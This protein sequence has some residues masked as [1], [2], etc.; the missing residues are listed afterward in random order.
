MSNENQENRGK[1]D[2]NTDQELHKTVNNVADT[3]MDSVKAGN[4]TFSESNYVEE[5][6]TR[7][8]LRNDYYDNMIKEEQERNR[9]LAEEERRNTK[10]IDNVSDKIANRM[11]EIKVEN[12]RRRAEEEARRLEYEKQ[13]QAAQDE[14]KRREAENNARRTSEGNDGRTKNSRNTTDDNARK[15]SE[16]NERRKQEELQKNDLLEREKKER[17]IKEEREKRNIV[18]ETNK[19]RATKQTSNTTNNKL[20]NMA[21]NLGDLAKNTAMGTTTDISSGKIP[22]NEVAISENSGVFD[23]VATPNNNGGNNGSKKVVNGSNE[24]E[25]NK[26]LNT[27]RRKINED[28]DYKKMLQ[29]M[30]KIVE[31]ATKDLKNTDV[32]QTY[33]KAQRKI[34]AVTSSIAYL[35][36]NSAARSA[37]N[38]LNRTNGTGLT[39]ALEQLG[40]KSKFEQR[41]TVVTNDEILGRQESITSVFQ[42]GVNGKNIGKLSKEFDLAATA[43]S[44]ER[45]FNGKKP[46]KMSVGEIKRILRR[47][48]GE[49]SDLDRALFDE[50][51]KFKNYQKYSGLVSKFNAMRITCTAIISPFFKDTDEAMVLSEVNNMANMVFKTVKMFK[52]GQTGVVK[53]TAAYVSKKLAKTTEPIRNVAAGA[54]NSIKKIDKNITNKF[55]NT[56]PMKKIS[57]SKFGRTYSKIN[58]SKFSQHPIK[59]LRNFKSKWDNRLTLKTHFKMRINGAL[60]KTKVGRFL[61]NSNSFIN[62]YNPM[63]LVAKFFDFFQQIKMALIKGVLMFIG[64]LMCIVIIL[65]ITSTLLDSNGYLNDFSDYV[66]GN[67]A[68]FFGDITGNFKINEDHT[69]VEDEFG[70][71][72][73]QSD[74][75][76]MLVNFEDEYIRELKNVGKDNKPTGDNGYRDTY[77]QKFNETF[78]DN[79]YIK[80]VDQSG[81]IIPYETNIKDILSLASTQMQQDRMKNIVVYNLYCS[82][83]WHWSHMYNIKSNASVTKAFDTYDKKTGKYKFDYS[84][85]KYKYDE[86][87]ETGDQIVYCDKKTRMTMQDTLDLLKGGAAKG[88]VLATC[89]QNAYHCSVVEDL[90][91]HKI[92]YLKGDGELVCWEY[93]ID[94]DTIN[95]PDWISTAWYIEKGT[96][97]IGPL[98]YNTNTQWAA[99]DGGFKSGNV[100]CTISGT[101]HIEEYDRNN[102]KSINEKY[103]HVTGRIFFDTV[104]TVKETVS[105]KVKDPET[106]EETTVAEIVERKIKNRTTYMYDYD[107]EDQELVLNNNIVLRPAECKIKRK[108]DTSLCQG[109]CGGHPYLELTGRIINIDKEKLALEKKCEDEGNNSSFEQYLDE[110]TIYAAVM[111]QKYSKQGLEGEKLDK[112]VEDEVLT[113][114]PYDLIDLD[115]KKHIISLINVSLDIYTNYYSVM[116]KQ[117]KYG[118]DIH[119]TYNTNKDL[120]KDLIKKK[121]GKKKLEDVN[122]KGLI[123]YESEIKERLM[124]LNAFHT[125]DFVDSVIKEIKKDPDLLDKIQD[126][127][128]SDLPNKN[129]KFKNKSEKN[130]LSLF[131]EEDKDFILID[132]CDTNQLQ[133][134]TSHLNDFYDIFFDEDTKKIKINTDTMDLTFLYINYDELKDKFA[135]EGKGFISQFIK[136][137]KEGIDN[138]SNNKYIDFDYI[139]LL[140]TGYKVN[141]NNPD[142]LAEMTSE[143]CL[144]RIFK[145]KY[146]NIINSNEIKASHESDKTKRKKNIQ[147]IKGEKIDIS[148]IDGLY[149]YKKNDTSDEE[150]FS[151]GEWSV[152]DEVW[153]CHF[154]NQDWKEEYKLEIEKKYTDGIKNLISAGTIGTEEMSENGYRLAGF[155]NDLQAQVVVEYCEKVYNSKAE[156]SMDRRYE[157]P[158]FYDCSSLAYLAWSAAGVDMVYPKTSGTIPTAALEASWLNNKKLLVATNTLK[159]VDL[160]PGDLI[161]YSTK[162]NRRYKNITH[163]AIYVGGGYRIHAQSTKTGIVKDNKYDNGAVVAYA[164]PSLL[165]SNVPNKIPGCKSDKKTYMAYTKVT[166]KDSDQY[167]LLNSKQAKTHVSYGIRMIGDRYCV[168]VGTGYLTGVKKYI[169]TKIDVEL[170]NGKVLKCIV[171]DI[172]DNRDTDK[173]NRFHKVDG[174]VV[175]FI[176]DNKIFGETDM[177][178]KAKLMGD[179]SYMED[180]I[181]EGKIKNI[182]IVKE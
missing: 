166:K 94:K 174:S 2:W 58:N 111:R 113:K 175:E 92:S 48:G 132:S 39:N 162:N 114:Y 106:G 151:M 62:K 100:E 30:G 119:D 44:L 176:I 145:T 53:T 110:R 135:Q 157:Y 83:L 50:L 64:F 13:K 72:M 107:V 71:D 57:N 156:Y 33:Y 105:K 104:E 172:K 78:G 20:H 16:A 17:R 76:K 45:F 169:G 59:T 5:W 182:K 36:A 142:N 137:M 124:E 46:S 8:S 40:R 89:C 159:G 27:Q 138:A 75:L 26:M 112:K 65:N 79:V 19:N 127:K 143:E 102:D 165:G 32:M 155:V 56:K 153:C 116:K 34:D 41:R 68:D 37:L 81:K 11:E 22:N 152:E 61:L 108:I 85:N 141:N 129:Y 74:S 38:E 12:E 69:V 25:V 84:G 29:T 10:G 109:H 6:E 123:Y 148:Q 60:S 173:T 63:K 149:M 96:L 42:V 88:R 139:N 21:N 47:H 24:E 171:G 168:A 23:R 101:H 3:K 80:W 86:G 181:F 131:F 134:D 146:Y 147:T 67:V 93:K 28:I 99:R 54:I 120:V 150:A 52:K 133:I 82:K 87:G 118:I 180:K 121:D 55:L 170:E 73:T 18:D 98:A 178:E 125:W 4:A 128:K 15:M 77:G 43:P 90:K 122:Y 140:K 97:N 49:M 51:L 163:V 177:S 66:M 130:I 1:Y 160:K 115:K 91:D 14:I 158:K 144:Q 95:V 126:L 164:S 161:F 117:G 136:I 35:A 9:I 154:Y 179:I 70:N 31:T 167:K 7:D 103:Q